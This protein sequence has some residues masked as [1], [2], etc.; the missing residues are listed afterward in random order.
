MTEFA[1]KLKYESKLNNLTYYSEKNFINDKESFRKVVY[2]FA[3]GTRVFKVSVKLKN[4]KTGQYIPVKA[5]WD[6]GAKNTAISE[7]RFSELG[8]EKKNIIKVSTANGIIE[9]FDCYAD[10]EFCRELILENHRLLVQD[11]PEDVDILIGTDIILLGDFSIRNC[12]DCIELELKLN[13]E[14]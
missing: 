14:N 10:L 11:L 5:I 3:K 8:L 6:T 1:T 4:P 12:D 13:N 2:E 7:I 9:S